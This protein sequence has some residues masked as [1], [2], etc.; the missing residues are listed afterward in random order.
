MDL[1]TLCMIKR[2]I[3]RGG[4]GRVGGWGGGSSEKH[5]KWGGWG[6]Y[7]TKMIG[8]GEFIR[9]FSIYFGKT[10]DIKIKQ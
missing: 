4:R 8:D 9:A 5:L 2:F 7:R 3:G 1:F 6:F 10:F